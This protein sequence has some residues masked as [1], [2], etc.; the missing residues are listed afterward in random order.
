MN[1][2]NEYRKRFYT[3]IEST[4]GDVKPLINELNTPEPVDSTKYSSIEFKNIGL[5]NPIGDKINPYLL[6]DVEMAASQAGVKASVTTAVSGHK[7]GSRHNPSGNAVDL[8]IFDGKGYS[9]EQDA[10]NKGIYDGIKRFVDTLQSM[11]YKVNSESGND[12]AV[13]WFGFA[14]HHH[15]VHVSRITYGDKKI[16]ID[17]L[18]KTWENKLTPKVKFLF[19]DKPELLKSKSFDG[20]VNRDYHTRWTFA[21]HRFIGDGKNGVTLSLIGERKDNEEELSDYYY[22]ISKGTEFSNSEREVLPMDD[23]NTTIV[24]S[25]TNEA[26]LKFKIYGSEF[27][28]WP[29]SRET[30][31]FDDQSYNAIGL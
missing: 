13:L 4:I 19:E 5:G 10:K 16:T 18:K 3:L 28:N 17:E 1:N 31:N 30:G 15:H 2:L 12:K 7:S 8:A 9:S 27:E 26:V 23:S 14:G 11:G 20:A 25:Q 21:E 29:A 22:E 6:D 24:D